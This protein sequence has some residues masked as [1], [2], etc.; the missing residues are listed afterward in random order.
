[1]QVKIYVCTL[2]F[3][4]LFSGAWLMDNHIKKITNVYNYNMYQLDS[5]SFLLHV[6]QNNQQINGLT[7][8]GLFKPREYVRKTSSP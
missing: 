8:S 3:W 4:A 5:N 7:R 6:E 2:I 1:M